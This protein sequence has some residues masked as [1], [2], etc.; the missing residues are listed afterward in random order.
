MAWHLK[1]SQFV[2]RIE[3]ITDCRGGDEG[4]ACVAA[5]M[6]EQRVSHFVG[7]AKRHVCLG[8]NDL[9]NLTAAISVSCQCTA[10]C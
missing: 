5:V 4:A 6:R 7:R 1:H 9:T 2:G 10:R 8:L 3:K